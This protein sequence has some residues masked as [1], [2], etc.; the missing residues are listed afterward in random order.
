MALYEFRTG[1]QLSTIDFHMEKIIKIYIHCANAIQEAGDS[2][3]DDLAFP[4]K[5]KLLRIAQKIVDAHTGIAGISGVLIL[6]DLR[7]CKLFSRG[8]TGL[9]YTE[10]LNL[11]HEYVILEE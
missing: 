7:R 4:P 3:L 8:G 9:S 1:V 6:F 10:L 5:E 11:Y 2:P